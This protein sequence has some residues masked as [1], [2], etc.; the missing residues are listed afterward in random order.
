VPIGEKNVRF[1]PHCNNNNIKTVKVNNILVLMMNS[2]LNQLV[3]NHFVPAGLE[4][5]RKTVKFKS[6]PP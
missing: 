4:Q 2:Q 3:Q 1:S 6:Q 5:Q